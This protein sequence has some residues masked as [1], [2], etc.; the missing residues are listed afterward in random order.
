[1]K[2]TFLVFSLLLV[3]I[4]L[5]AKVDAQDL[6][7]VQIFGGLTFLDTSDVIERPTTGWLVGGVWNLTEKFGLEIHISRLEHSQSITF[8]TIDSRFLTLLAGPIKTWRFGLVQSFGH[9]LLG[10]TQLDISAVSDVPFPLSGSSQDTNGTLLIG[11]GIEIPLVH[12]LSTR[13]GY[14][15]RKIF[16][17]KSYNQ[18]GIYLSAVYGF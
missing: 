3:V 6:P 12:R 11:G 1:M 14:D 8:L 2:T 18:H 15:Y 5:P 4:I 10:T 13:L 17:V 9:L 7:P 16:A